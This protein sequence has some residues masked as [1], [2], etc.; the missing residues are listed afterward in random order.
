MRGKER[1]KERERERGKSVN[2]KKG[3]K[4]YIKSPPVDRESKQIL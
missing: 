4:I 1:E 3:K 2:C